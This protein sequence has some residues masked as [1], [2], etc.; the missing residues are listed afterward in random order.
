LQFEV[1]LYRLEA[2]YGA[3]P[4]MEPAPYSH[5][6][7]FSPGVT[8]EQFTGKFLGD[9]VRLAHDIRNQ[10]VILF[11]DNWKLDYFVKNHPDLALHQVSPHKMEE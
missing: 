2:E 9:G 10:L 6:R 4:R 7:W 3:E 11:P 1:V 5:I 8:E